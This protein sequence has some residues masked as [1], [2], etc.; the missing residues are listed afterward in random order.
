MPLSN[1]VSLLNKDLSEGAQKQ[2]ADGTFAC[3]RQYGEHIYMIALFKFEFFSKK[4]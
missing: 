4:Y 3:S 2:A 1:F